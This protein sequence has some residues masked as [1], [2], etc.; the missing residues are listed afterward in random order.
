M[1]KMSTRTTQAEAKKILMITLIVTLISVAGIALPYPILAPLFEQGESALTQFQGLPKELLLGIVL[2][3]YPLG[4]I[5]GSS[6]IGALSDSYGRRRLLTLT[7]VGSGIGYSA[8]AFAALSGNF[9]LFC[10]ARLMT[11]VC[12]GN[13]S[14]ARAIAADLHPIID[15]TRSF[16][17]ISA[18]GY[19]GYLLGPLMGGYLIYSGIE[20]VFIV[21]AIACFLCAGLSHFLMP[22]SL[23]E[24]TNAPSNASSL[25]L[26]RQ[27]DLRRFFMLYL[28]LTMG[29]NL[30]YEFYPLFLVR[31]F[32]YTPVDISWATVFLTACMIFTSIW[33]NPKIQQTMSHARAGL[34]G[35]IIFGSAL[36][37]LPFLT[38]QLYLICFAL[39]GA[40]IAIYN[41]FL[42]VYLSNSYH[43]N[44]QG[45]LMG[46][47]VTIFCLGNLLAAGLGSILSILDV[48]WAL[49]SGAL[50][51]FFAAAVFFHGHYR[52]KI[53]PQPSSAPA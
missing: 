41:G 14:I 1:K 51:T 8:T 24:T 5:I 7:L 47:L 50:V 10:I 40:G 52:A 4:I 33:I 2:G 48:K 38:S 13:I 19:G 46:M 6:F 12:E 9:A 26:L 18:M 21:A 39:M 11:G 25:V 20:T 45:Q 30:Y 44:A 36:T 31:Q 17:L 35:V 23:N 16:S 42:P 27:V 43:N 15:K 49:L 32:S 34:M 28:L 3:V 22:S 53:W 29:V 37:A